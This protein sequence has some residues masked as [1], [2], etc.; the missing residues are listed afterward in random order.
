MVIAVAAA[1]LFVASR[2][3]G[4]ETTAPYNP[5]RFEADAINDAVAGLRPA[6]VDF[7]DLAAGFG[8]DNTP[9]TP[10]QER[11]LRRGPSVR[12]PVDVDC[13]EPVTVSA[14]ADNFAETVE[15]AEPGTCFRLEPGEYRF[16]DVKP[17]DYMTFLGSS[18]AEVVVQGDAGTEN[19]FS[20]TATGVTIGRMTI[21]GFQGDGGEKRQEQ[22]AIRGSRGIWLSDRGTLAVNWLIDD[23]DI[24]DNYAT[25]IN[26]GDDFTVRN[27]RLWANGVS[28]IGGSD[29]EG[30]YIHD[31]EIFDNGNLG[32][33]SGIYSTSSGVK[34]TQA[35]LPHNHLVV[36]RNKFYGNTGVAI[37][38]D[39]GCDGFTA[40]DNIVSDFRYGIVVEISST[41]YIAN[42]VVETDSIDGK[43]GWDSGYAGIMVRES[44]DVLVE[45]N[46]VIGGTFGVFAKQHVRPG[47]GE[48][49]LYNYENVTFETSN[50]VFR[51]NAIR[52]AK[53]VGVEVEDSQA[54]RD[55]IDL[56]SVLFVDNIYAEPTDVDFYWLNNDNVSLD[57]WQAVGYDRGGGGFPQ[58]PSWPPPKSASAFPYLLTADDGN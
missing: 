58:K 24:H 16:H 50:V 57:D 43:Y 28:G 1:G 8:S 42:N 56:E 10:E 40:T 45:N 11:E 29:L 23:V 18:R 7:A 53:H 4:I 3:S 54:A 34:F 25:G 5:A 9:M 37:W 13:R 38:C 27:S 44:K 2:D 17:K 15:N 20:G 31:N 41:A 39:I 52:D 30:G 32:E 21:R 48:D 12:R 49:F 35:G 14:P 22:G 26:I 51:N 36:T 55:A 6:P 47:N 19:A 46:H 33:A